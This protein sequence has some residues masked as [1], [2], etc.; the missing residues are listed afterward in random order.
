[1]T[2]SRAVAAFVASSDAAASIVVGA[3]AETAGLAESEDAVLELA[4]AVLAGQRL[5]CYLVPWDES[6]PDFASSSR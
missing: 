1:M 5:L 2:A 6:L 4:S 3:D